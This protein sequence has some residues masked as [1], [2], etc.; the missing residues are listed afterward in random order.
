MVTAAQLRAA[1]GLLDWAQE[2][3]A[4]MAGL[5]VSTVKRMESADTGPSKSSLAN[6][7]AVCRALEKGG[8][9]FLP[10]NGHGPGV[11]LRDGKKG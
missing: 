7:E 11:Q 4:K 8:V 2:H 9:Q 3:L 6:V 10:G 5:S 1:R